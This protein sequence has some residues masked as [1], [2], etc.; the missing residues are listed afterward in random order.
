MEVSEKDIKR[1]WKKVDIKGEDECW[2]WLA[3][4]NYKGYGHFNKDGKITAAHRF[5]YMIHNNIKEIPSNICVC[6]T[7]DNPSCQNPKHLF[8]GTVSDNN[9][10]RDNKKRT[11]HPT[12]ET[13]SRTKLKNEDVLYMRELYATGEHTKRSL[14]EKFCLS[15]SMVDKIV[16]GEYWK[17]VGGKITVRRAGTCK[18][19]ETDVRIIREM[20]K[21]GIYNYDEIAKKFGVSY[22]NIIYIKNNRTWK[23]III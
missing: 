4:K 21:N 16:R 20:I 11:Y 18:L 15:V 13:H 7:C 14:S 3:S 10:D 6:H 19:T 2:D 1:Y 22:S 5:S 9:K 23:D 8:L 12:G 17:D